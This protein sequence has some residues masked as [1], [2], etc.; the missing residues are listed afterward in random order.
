MFFLFFVAV[1]SIRP[2]NHGRWNVIRVEFCNF[3]IMAETANVVIVAKI[4]M[5]AIIAIIAILVTIAEV[6]VQ[7]VI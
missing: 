1:F 5:V 2:D 6:V 7:P 4:A 3:A